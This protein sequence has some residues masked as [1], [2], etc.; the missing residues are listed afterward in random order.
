M[1]RLLDYLFSDLKQ[2]LKFIYMLYTNKNYF[3]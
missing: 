2:V 3:F 1:K